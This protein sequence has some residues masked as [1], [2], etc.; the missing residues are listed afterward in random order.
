MLFLYLL[1]F[2]KSQ[3]AMLTDSPPR[4]KNRA[5]FLE[6]DRIKTLDLPQD[7]RLLA[8]AQSIESA[9]RAGATAD[10]RR[11]CT[12]F[13]GAA[14]EFYKVSECGIR[15]LAARPLR[16]RE[17]W[18]T[19]LFGDYAPETMLIRLWMRTAVRKEITSYGTFLSTLCHEFCHHL[20]F[21]RFKFHDGGKTAFPNAYEVKALSPHHRFVIALHSP[22]GVA[23]TGL[24][25]CPPE[26]NARKLAP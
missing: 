8:I 5:G 24:R 19:E 12:E 2:V 26:K 6:S 25:V 4:K 15:V 23:E 11:T 20:D 13:L 14:S 1:I 22:G 7:G 18:S 16:V 10:V 9:M 21:H 3:C 17:N